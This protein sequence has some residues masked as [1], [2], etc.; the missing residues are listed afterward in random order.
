MPCHLLL[1]SAKNLHVFAIAIANQLTVPTVLLFNVKGLTKNS[2][3]LTPP[4]PLF[5]PPST[6]LEYI[7]GLSRALTWTR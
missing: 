2:L 3:Y 1:H 4:T 5:S 6:P 7:R